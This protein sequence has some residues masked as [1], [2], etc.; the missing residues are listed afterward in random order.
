MWT[1]LLLVFVSVFI[2]LGSVEF[3]LRAYDLT[4]GG[5]FF[6]THGNIF[7]QPT[8]MPLPAPGGAGR[9]IPFRMFGFDPYRMD[10]S[11]RLISSRWGEAYPYRKTVGTYRIVCFGGS[12]TEDRVDG[13]HY[14]LVLQTLLRQRLHRDNIEVINVA[15]SAY[16][17]PHSLILLT[18]DVVSWEPDL[19]IVSHNINDLLT[20]YFP[21]FRPDYWNKFSHPFYMGPDYSERYSWSNVVFQHS[22]LYWV[23]KDGLERLRRR[24]TPLAAGIRRRSYGHAPLPEAAAVFRR[25][26]MTFAAIAKAWNITTLIGSQPLQPSEELFLI[27]M[28]E[29]PYNDVAVYPYHEEFVHHYQAFN[30]IAAEAAT[31]AGV[32]FVDN[33]KRL[34][35][36]PKYFIDHVHYTKEGIIALA[37]SYA[38]YIIAHNLI[39]PHQMS[40]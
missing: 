18:L 1:N 8:L 5:S 25:N 37:D 36:N 29:K 40:H 2:T 7:Y 38:D 19:V 6:Q 39:P 4:Q 28:R 30:R 11:Q 33:A 35:G 26:L 34:G 21:G 17:T 27:H 20:M 22:R 24:I 3:G 10:G 31:N 23:V 15:N 16:A 13:L 9:V 14:P 12:T 32:G